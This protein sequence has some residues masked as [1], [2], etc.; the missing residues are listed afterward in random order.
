MEPSHDPELS[1][2]LWKASRLAFPTLVRI[3]GDFDLAEDALQD[4]TCVALE[5]WARDG[6]PKNPPSWLISTARFKAIDQLRKQSK[7]EPISIWQERLTQPQTIEVDDG[8][9]SIEDDM[10]RLIF[11]CCHPAISREAQIALT[12]REVCNL[13]TEEIAKAFLIE[14]ATVA[15]RI[16]RAKA[17]I[18]ES[19][20]PF[21]VP[22]NSQLPTR[23]NSVLRVIYLVFNEGYSASHGNDSVRL[24][25][26]NEAV[27]IAG[28]V[29]KTFPQPEVM[30][31]MA[32]LTLHQAR[33]PARFFG[34]GEI[35]P[36]EEQDRSRWNH[37]KIEEAVELMHKSLDSGA[38]GAYTLQAAI[39]SVHSQADSFEKTDWNQIVTL[40][41]ALLE[42]DPSPIVELNQAVAIARRD[43]PEYALP[44]VERL[45]SSAGLSKY[46]LAHAV[47]GDL[48]RRLEKRDEAAH[49]YETAITLT[50]EASAQRFLLRKLLQSRGSVL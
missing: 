30:G 45:I 1:Q 39:A 19:K 23:L 21:V 37:P 13:T 38:Y 17:K 28:I 47:K 29:L 33:M 27:R 34:E 4:A 22:D 46:S 11:T 36:L 10:V 8:T 49:A 41:D 48:C 50:S 32:L 3:L 26:V 25:L 9:D 40:Y 24:E 20:I 12:L 2:I 16:V 44:I 7:L 14:K 42:I 18:R 6:I 31:L 43:G 15:Q 5:V 35:V